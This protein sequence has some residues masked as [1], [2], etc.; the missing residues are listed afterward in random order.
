MKYT[1]KFKLKCV[2]RYKQSHSYVYPPGVKSKHSFR[3]HVRNWVRLYDDLGIDGLRHSGTKKEW[4]AHDR[5]GLVAKVLTG[6]SIS[7]VA[8]EA[9]ISTG[10]LYQWV[11]RYREK[12]MDG[13]ECRRGKPPKVP[14]I[15]LKKKTELTPSEREELEILRAR[16]EYLEAENEYLKKLDA[17]VTE[18]EAARPKARKRKSSRK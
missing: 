13:L 5:F 10:Q 3:S 15:M 16:N 18:R 14:I 1:L 2:E 9:H 4:T 12:G 7:D 17:L 6:R 11:K 8:G